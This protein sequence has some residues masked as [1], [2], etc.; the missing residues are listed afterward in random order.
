M[1]II[2]I[3]EF[4]AEAVEPMKAIIEALTASD[5]TVMLKVSGETICTVFQGAIKKNDSPGG[6]FPRDAKQDKSKRVPGTAK[7]QIRI[8]PDF[9]ELP[10]DIAQS[11]GVID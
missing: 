4:S 3:E 1:K 8:A 9:D 7:G 11:F 6:D 2:N 5:E 10:E